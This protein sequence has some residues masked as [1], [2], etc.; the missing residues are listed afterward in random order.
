MVGLS[1]SNAK[2]PSKI[3]PK[4]PA[5]TKTATK[6][7][8]RV[9]VEFE[10]T[11][12]AGTGGED[13]GEDDNQEEEEDRMVEENEEEEQE[14][15]EEEDMEAAQEAAHETVREAAQKAA[16]E[17]ARKAEQEAAREAERDRYRLFGPGSARTARET[18]M[19][20]HS[21]NIEQSRALLKAEK[22]KAAAIA[23][24]KRVT[25]GKKASAA[26]IGNQHPAEKVPPRAKKARINTI[27]SPNA[28]NV[29]LAE[30]LA[31]QSERANLLQQLVNK[32]NEP[33]LLS[34]IA[35]LQA[36][37]DRLSERTAA[38]ENRPKKRKQ[39]ERDE[40]EDVAADPPQPSREATPDEPDPWKGFEAT[41][42][43]WALV[44]AYEAGKKHG[45]SKELL[46]REPDP[47]P[48][49]KRPPP[50][51]WITG[52]NVVEARASRELF[53]RLLPV[54]EGTQKPVWL[55]CA[56]SAGMKDGKA[57]K[58]CS[59]EL[60]L[61][62]SYL[63]K[64]RAHLDKKR[65][66]PFDMRNEVAFD[67]DVWCVEVR[68]EG[69]EES[70]T[71]LR[72]S[73]SDRK[74]GSRGTSSRGGISLTIPKSTELPP[75]TSKGKKGASVEK[76][77]G[78]LNQDLRWLRKE[79]KTKLTAATVPDQR[80]RFIYDVEGCAKIHFD[81]SPLWREQPKAVEMIKMHCSHPN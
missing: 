31:R 29:T 63:E 49:D 35:S 37:V 30:E 10:S 32:H 34:A 51:T 53:D 60:F 78:L 69:G 12:F 77:L 40:E 8:H 39:R 21:Q 70:T 28:V 56:R 38:L 68:T 33:A 43:I 76:L 45:R 64:S 71:T 6:P 7:K 11:L 52:S 54:I 18:L 36:S 41:T 26:L 15:G 3:T 44:Q 50:I 73:E 79:T 80:E 81:D 22:A 67:P 59:L 42:D 46:G 66:T 74:R 17:A 55:W 58:N 16:Q 62:Q 19:K 72:H 57:H 1:G 4:G 65:A 5:I 48:E 14:E 9:D 75:S 61:T 2:A 25:K 27:P 20:L 24:R 23:E 47:V 13:M